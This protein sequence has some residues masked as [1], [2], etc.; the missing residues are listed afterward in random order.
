MPDLNKIETVQVRIVGAESQGDIAG[1]GE[2]VK[3]LVLLYIS[4]YTTLGCILLLHRYC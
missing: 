1:V 2:G 3:V 4:Y